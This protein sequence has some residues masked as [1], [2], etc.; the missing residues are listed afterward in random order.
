[1]LSGL[2]GD[3]WEA[4]GGL[5]RLGQWLGNA[6]G[7]LGGL[8]RLGE[9]FG[10]L[11]GGSGTVGEV[12]GRFGEC[13][14]DALGRLGEAWGLVPYTFGLSGEAW[15]AWCGLGMLGSAVELVVSNAFIQKA[16]TCLFTC[17]PSHL[18]LYSHKGTRSPVSGS[19]LSF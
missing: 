17:H 2:I 16:K 6:L 11:W 14:G 5:G 9:C 8:R 19:S 4:W 15:E 13:S 7:K 12:W 18:P 3:A 10:M 1:M